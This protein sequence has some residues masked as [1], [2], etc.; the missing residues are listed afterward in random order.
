MAKDYGI[1]YGFPDN[2]CYITVYNK[3]QGVIDLLIDP[4]VRC[5][6]ALG[7]VIAFEHEKSGDNIR[8]KYLDNISQKQRVEGFDKA[9]KK[10]VP[11]Y[12]GK[13]N[14]SGYIC[15]ATGNDCKIATNHFERLQNTI[16]QSVKD[17]RTFITRECNLCAEHD[18]P[19]WN[20]YILKMVE[21]YSKSNVR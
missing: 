4:S 6:S 15:R 14:I 13:V 8:C 7:D 20:N 12:A 10:F 16:K 21:E 18:C 9:Y 11:L 1:L 2:E 5:Y 3:E 19:V 17:G